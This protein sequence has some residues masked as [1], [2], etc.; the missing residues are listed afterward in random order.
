[1]VPSVPGPD[2]AGLPLFEVLTALTSL[3]SRFVMTVSLAA[4]VC[5]VA[6]AVPARAAQLVTRFEVVESVFSPDGD[7]KID[8]SH[9]QY[10]L[11]DTATAVSIVVFAADSVTPVDTL[12]AP[13]PGVPPTIHRVAW[14]GRRWNGSPAPEGAY[15]VTMSATGNSANYTASLPVFID[16]T[17]PTIQI[18]SVTPDPYAPGLPE[19]PA[20][21]ISFLVGNASPIY[22]GRVADQLATAITDPS[23]TAVKA[24]ALVTTPAFDGASGSYVM[25]WDASADV[26]NLADGEYTI[27]LT[28]NDAAGY[29]A[30]S[31]YHV[32]VDTRDPTI[33]VTSLRENASVAVVPD[34]LRGF[35]LDARGIDSL[36]V[37]Y[38]S[39]PF[40]Q[41]ATTTTRDDSLWFAVS[42]A[43]HIA[44]EGTHDIVFRAVDRARRAA[45][46]IFPFTFD[47]T[48]PAAPSLTPFHGTWRTATYR[49]TGAADNGG[50]AAAVVRILRNGVQV[51]S[52]LTVASPKFAVDV[53]LVRGRNDIVGIL[54]DGAGNVSPPSN[55]VTVTFDESSG[56]YAPA[57]FTPGAAFDINAPRLARGA[58]LR[59]FDLAGDLI[60]LFSN[61]SGRQFYT[62][63]WDGRNSSGT[64]VKRGP[65]VA[66]ATLDYG[67]GSRDVF[68]AVFLYDPDAR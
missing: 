2:G 47:A 65:L 20:D 22:S 19:D 21:R 34:S 37:A 43:E 35:A 53:P 29:S 50:D 67:D 60:T 48:P 36:Y 9:V 38:P 26:V 62:F 46:F 58:E 44:T 52:A 10:A 64:N 68:R 13:S 14:D 63:P 42:L 41:V 1:M 55:T 12:R 3:Q 11:G 40:V 17:P 23:G 25:T 39:S 27:S 45:R 5:C 24:P 49:V 56:L 54:R 6:A 59:V 66:V 61:S 8:S 18:I 31:V 51:D 4:V 32:I 57:P 7:S 33:K 30:N 15:I 28:L 16:V